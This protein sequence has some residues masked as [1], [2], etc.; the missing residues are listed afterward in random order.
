MGVTRPSR[1]Y[2]FPFCWISLAG[3]PSRPTNEKEDQMLA[4][5][6]G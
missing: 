2:A 3:D 4:S 6:T 1:S 5:R